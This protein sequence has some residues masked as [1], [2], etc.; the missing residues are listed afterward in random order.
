MEVLNYSDLRKNLAEHLD[1]VAEAEEVLIVARGHGKNVVLISL[2]TYNSL[3][4]TV[5]LQSNNTNSN[6]LQEAISEMNSGKFKKGKL[7][8]A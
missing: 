6:R 3:L 1:V 4:E 7:K 5:H 8:T 2:D